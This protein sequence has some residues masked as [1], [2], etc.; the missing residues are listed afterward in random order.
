[1]N[2][3]KQTRLAVGQEK[4]PFF[5]RWPLKSLDFKDRCH[6]LNYFQGFNNS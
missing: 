4:R 6:G 3:T 5:T 2:K 1:M